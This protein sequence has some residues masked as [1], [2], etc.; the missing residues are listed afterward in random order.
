MQKDIFIAKTESI[1]DVL[2]KLDRTAEKL[3]LVTDP[4]N[5]LL[6]TI[7]DGDIR[8]YLLK[9]NSLDD[10][11]ENVYYRNPTFLRKGE[12]SMEAARKIF[13]KKKINLIPVID[14]QG[15]VVDYIIW[16]QAFSEHT[17][18]PKNGRIKVPV[19]IMAGGRG[20]RLEP[21]TK[22]LP[23]PLI[24]VN[25]KPVIELIIEEF[26]RQGGKRFYLILNSKGEMIEAYFN[27]VEKDY[28]VRF[29]RENDFLGT[30]G[31]LKLL[32][33]MNTDI[34]IVTNCDVIVKA[35]FQQVITLHKRQNAVMTV[36]SS[37][38]HHKIPYG[39]INFR[40]KGLVTDIHE[41]PE[42]TVTI[43]TGVYVL[44][45]E[46][47]RFIPEN[48][49]F[50]M[51]DLIKKLIRNNKKVATYPV[52]ENDY[53]DIGQWEEYKNAVEKLGVFG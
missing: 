8:R 13:L 42:Y 17:R 1:K 37:I 52:N 44:S 32:R 7:S 40:E 53:I 34:F 46:A 23:K 21:F 22:I 25:D 43:N 26:K 30:A 11:I 45:R 29:V 50:D 48:T 4:D 33:R 5:R 38:Q 19:V 35:D 49:S 16:N 20:T 24:P 14:E 18:P 28:E 6:G 51:T 3:L 15:T 41:K 31:G 12:F 10:N 27:G 47:V 9:G 2:K 36:L 39:V